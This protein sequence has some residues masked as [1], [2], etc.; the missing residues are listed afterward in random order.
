MTD[1]AKP[2]RCRKGRGLASGRFV[3]VA[4]VCLMPGLVLTGCVGGVMD[5]GGQSPKVDRSISTGTIQTEPEKRS[6]QDTVRN[7]VSSADIEK[8]GQSPIPWANTSTGSA[9]VIS[10]IS[11]DRSNGTVCRMFTTSRHAYDGVAK[12]YGRTCLAGDGQW[13]LVNFDQQS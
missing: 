5:F 11:E 2:D 7:A 6:D 1:I 8:V 13:Q 10:S 12:F 9:G 4:A 3:A